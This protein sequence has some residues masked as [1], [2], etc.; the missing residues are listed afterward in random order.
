MSYIESRDVT[1]GAIQRLARKAGV[2]RIGGFIYE[3]MRGRI[4]VYLEP[5][6]KVA[7]IAAEDQKRVRVQ[8]NDVQIAL[9]GAGRTP[10]SRP[11]TQVNRRVNI[12]AMRESGLVR[13]PSRVVQSCSRNPKTA[14][15]VRYAPQI[16]RRRKPGVRALQDVRAYQKQSPCFSIAKD[17]FRRIVTRDTPT[18]QW[19]Q[20]AL[21]ILQTDVESYM[22]DLLKNAQMTAIHAGRQTIQPKDLQLAQ[23]IRADA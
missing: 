18:N 4:S 20:E 1:N 8:V 6:V 5:L 12:D 13:I 10:Y 15:A 19:S 16:T 9:K 2:K 3:E 11:C 17:A 7:T 23:Y 21:D 22:I 14:C